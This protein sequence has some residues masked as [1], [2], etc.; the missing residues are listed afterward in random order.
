MRTFLID[1]GHGGEILGEYL[2]P[3]KRSPEVPP[4][5]YEGVFNRQVARLLLRPNIINLS[6]SPFDTSI[7]TRIKSIN[8]V[9]A[10]GHNVALISIHANAKGFGRKWYENAIGYRIFHARGA[11]EF[12]KAMARAV[13]L[14]FMEAP[15]IPATVDNPIR[16]KNFAIIKKVKC[17]AILI[18]CGF[19]TSKR[20]LSYLKNKMEIA[21][22]ILR[23]IKRIEE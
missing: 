4:G 7:R 13:D 10:R 18:E 3:G 21:Q 6:A 19:M 9:V 23:A 12:S 1:A 20:D 2:T 5:I 16:E 8:K 14:E 22:C 11:C 17:P 15:S